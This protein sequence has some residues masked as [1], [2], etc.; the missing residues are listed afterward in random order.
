MPAQYLFAAAPMALLAACAQ[1]AEAPAPAD[2][3]AV[4]DMLSANEKGLQA[5]F[6][7][8]DLEA[9][10]AFYAQDAT[11]FGGGSPPAEGREAIRASFEAMLADE[12]SSLA[13]NRTGSWVAA[14]GELAVTQASYTFSFTGEDGNRA[15]VEGRNQTVWVKQADGRWKIASDFNSPAE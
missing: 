1:P 6:N 3:E 5:A 4:L 13:L 14:S 15:S 8:K 2:P 10:V 7:D 12:N 9:G 11:F